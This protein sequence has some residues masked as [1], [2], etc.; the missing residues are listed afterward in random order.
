MQG[1]LVVEVGGPHYQRDVVTDVGDQQ[2]AAEHIALGLETARGLPVEKIGNGV[3]KLKRLR[4]SGI[5]LGK[6][7]VGAWRYLTDIE[8]KNLKNMV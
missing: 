4:V 7:K 1:G 3:V 6:L 2:N 8:I 5:F